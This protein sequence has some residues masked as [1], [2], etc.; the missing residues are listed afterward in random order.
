MGPHSQAVRGPSLASPWERIAPSWGPADGAGLLLPFQ[1]K[2]RTTWGGV[3]RASLPPAMRCHS[4]LVFGSP[5]SLQPAHHGG[6]GGISPSECPRSHPAPRKEATMACP[7]A[8]LSP[9][10]I[11][12]RGTSPGDGAV[13]SASGLAGPGAF[14]AG[15]VWAALHPWGWYPTKRGLAPPEPTQH[16]SS[17]E[18]ALG[19]LPSPLISAGSNTGSSWIHCVDC[20]P[21]GGL[22]LGVN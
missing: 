8:G 1:P 7:R 10:S 18:G 2:E 17:A 11:L 14:G 21:S 3:P 22:L 15:G 16:Q 12:P 4:P 6:G 19:E 9:G 5:Q 20:E 13:S